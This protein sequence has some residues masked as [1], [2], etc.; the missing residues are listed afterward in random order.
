V[1]ALAVPAQMIG[2]HAH[3][4]HYV[5]RSHRILV[6]S[7]HAVYPIYFLVE[8]IKLDS[9]SLLT[10]VPFVFLLAIVNTINDSY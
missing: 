7:Y 4:A 1:D 9:V 5:G 10:V 2:T 8:L 3:V 6:G